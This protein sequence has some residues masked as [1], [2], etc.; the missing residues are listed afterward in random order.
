MTW[1]L[2]GSDRDDGY[3]AILTLH[4]ETLGDATELLLNIRQLPDGTISLYG[5]A[6]KGAFSS[7]GRR[8]DR[9]R[10]IPI[11]T[12]RLGH[13]HQLRFRGSSMFFW[14]YP[15]VTTGRMLVSS[16]IKMGGK[17]FALRSA[18]NL[19]VKLP[20]AQIAR[21]VETCGSPSAPASRP[22]AM[23]ERARDKPR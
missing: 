14:K 3:E 6:G 12:R 10:Q 23:G 20:A 11:A 19:V 22:Q 2:E 9:D 4:F 1:S 5:M 16:G 21:L 17:V 7:E 18:Q 13:A 15:K 8:P